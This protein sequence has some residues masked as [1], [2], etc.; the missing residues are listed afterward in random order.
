MG[1]AISYILL[2]ESEVKDRTTGQGVGTFFL[3]TGQT[4]GSALI[5]MLVAT[6]NGAIAGYKSAFLVAFVVSALLVT[7][8]GLLRSPSEERAVVTAG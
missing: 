7:A 6:Q 8:S 1:S 2:G 5:G 3:A 4:L